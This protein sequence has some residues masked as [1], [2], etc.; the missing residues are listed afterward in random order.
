MQLF[1]AFFTSFLEK[2]VFLAQIEP[3]V[4][5]KGSVILRHVTFVLPVCIWPNHW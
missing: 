5:Q 4:M 2:F 1:Y 3:T